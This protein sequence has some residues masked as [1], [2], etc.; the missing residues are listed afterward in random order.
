MSITRSLRIVDLFCGAGGMSLG[1]L[2]AAGE[3]GAQL[4]AAVDA[5]E[6]LSELY[7]TNLCETNFLR[8]EFGDAFEADEADAVAGQLGLRDDDVNV[9]LAGP[10]CQTFSAAGKRELGV[11]SRLGYHVCDLARLWQPEVVLIENVPEFSRAE[12]G[13]L[14]GRIR[15]RLLDAGYATEVMHLNAV[16]YGIPQTRTRCF[17]LGLRLDLP[18]PTHQDILA[19]L[20]LAPK[21]WKPRRNSDAAPAR[22]TT[23]REAL[24]DLPPLAAGEGEQVATY[25]NPAESDYQ[26]YLRGDQKCLF[27]HM[28][29][30]HSPELLAAMEMLEPGATPQDIQNHPLRRKD[31]YRGAYARLAPNKPSATMTTQTQ[32]PGSGRF[33]H[34]RDHRVLTVREVARLQGFPDWFRFLGTQADQRRHVGNAVPPLLAETIASTLMSLVNL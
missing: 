26:Q 28:A 30:Q 5:D 31:Y 14:L 18:R 12:D 34:Y 33:T 10:P 13:R 7:Q 29:G 19:G 24:S 25:V 20:Q 22:A 16:D 27:N 3:S 8:H 9:L 17:T 21:P 4:V 23:V 15:V 32:N 2:R 6:S 1:W 11:E